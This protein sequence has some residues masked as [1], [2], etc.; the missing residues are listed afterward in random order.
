MR[1]LFDHVDWRVRSLA[2]VR[3]FYVNFLAAVGFPEIEENAD[4]IGFSAKRDDPKPEFIGVIEDRE[5]RPNA[6]R[7]AFWAETRAEVDRIAEVVRAAGGR[8]VEGPMLNPEYGPDYY[9]MFFEDP[10]GNRL[11]VCCRR[12]TE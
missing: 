10:G 12:G 9:A 6:T 4:W 3:G 11:E 7:L 5:H 1:R 8:N 2:E